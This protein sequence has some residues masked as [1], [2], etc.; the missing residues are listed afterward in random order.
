MS[1]FVGAVTVEDLDPRLYYGCTWAAGRPE[2][3]NA[4]PNQ[5][6]FQA[7]DLEHGWFLCHE[8]V[9]P[10]RRLSLRQVG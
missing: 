3:R 1:Y 10:M 6:A 7:F 9:G 2:D 5:A 4:C 8:H